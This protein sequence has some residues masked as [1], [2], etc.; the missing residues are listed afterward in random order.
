[1]RSEAALFDDLRDHLRATR[2]RTLALARTFHGG[3]L[4]GPQLDIVNPPLW[5]LGHIAWFQELW[6]LREP[7]GGRGVP[8]GMREADACYDSSAIAHHRRWTLPLPS[9]ADTLRYLDEVHDAVIAKVAQG[10]PHLAYHGRLAA[11]HEDMHAEAFAYTGQTLAYEAPYDAQQDASGA[12]PGDAAI[13]GGEFL[14]GAT[15]GSAFVFDN[16]QWAVPTVVAPFRM[17]KAP[18]TQAEFAAFVD[19]GGYARRE[20]WC[21]AGWEW[22]CRAAATQPVY[23]SRGEMDWCERR[24]DRVVPLAP[25]RPVVHVNWYEAQAWCRWA[26]RRLPSEA[27]W[28]FAAATV[29]A[30]PGVKRLRPWGDEPASP[31]LANLYFGAGGCVDVA[32]CPAGDSAWG[33]RQLLGNVWEWTADDFRPYPGFAPGPY[34]DYSQPWFGTHKVLRGGGHQTSPRLAS[35]QYRNFF[36]PDRRDV[37][38]GF[39][40]CALNGS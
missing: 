13:A 25:H 3:R 12:W 7:R 24:H 4:L 31:P 40:T 11:F 1:M 38:A 26:G 35:T 2:A 17:A 34:R 18:V 29:P 5:E 22:R 19:E 20:W 28:E 27:E 37:Y 9:L 6:C 30:A 14:L 33:V 8:S 15:P 16:E 23:W 39:R 10:D 21:D 36:T 32:A